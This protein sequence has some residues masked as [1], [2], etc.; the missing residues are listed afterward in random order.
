M[1]QRNKH[2][3]HTIKFQILGLIILFIVNAWQYESTTITQAKEGRSEIQNK[4]TQAG[5]K[6]SNILVV[7]Q[8]FEF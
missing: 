3:S 7:L 4:R 6:E 1:M 8:S 2:F 5:N